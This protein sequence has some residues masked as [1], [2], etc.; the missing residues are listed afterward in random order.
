VIIEV[1]DD[2]MPEGVIAEGPCRLYRHFDNDGVLLYVGISLSAV[3]RLAQH[4]SQSPWFEEIATIRVEVYPSRAA[5]LAAETRAI[6]TEAPRHNKKHGDTVTASE[7]HIAGKFRDIEPKRSFE[8]KP[9]Y[10]MLGAQLL[11]G[12]GEAPL[13]ALIDSGALKHVVI[14][15]IRGR[16]SG[17]RIAGWHVIEMLDRLAGVEPDDE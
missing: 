2:Q 16:Y 8:F 13:R 6:Q 5:A 12:I 7:I 17:V 14:P 4:R 10:D 9:V 1:P 3:R 11:L 15:G